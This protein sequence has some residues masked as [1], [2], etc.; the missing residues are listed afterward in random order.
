MDSTPG[1]SG[2]TGPG[3]GEGGV[4]EG[5]NE[6][7]KGGVEGVREHVECLR[8]V[9]NGR[10]EEEVSGGGDGDYRRGVGVGGYVW[11]R[12]WAHG[13]DGGAQECTHWELIASGELW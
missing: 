4:E 3:G 5:E 1:W 10:D 11:V 13:G 2:D 6:S 12:A 7:N 9:Y 8:V